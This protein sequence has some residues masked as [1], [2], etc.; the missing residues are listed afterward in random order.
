MN[1]WERKDKWDLSGFVGEKKQ[2]MMDIKV[3]VQ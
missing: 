1:K 2:E 3:T